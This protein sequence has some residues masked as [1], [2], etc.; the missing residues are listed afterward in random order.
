MPTRILTA[1]LL[2]LTSLTASAHEYNFGTLH[3][4]HPHARAT[5][6]QQPA[7]AAWVSIE[8]QGKTADRLLS[9]SSPIAQSSELHEMSM[10]GDVMKMR[11]TGPMEIRPGEK[12]IMQAGGYH[13]MLM[14]LKQQLKAGDKFPLTL[15]F[16]KAGKQEV[17]VTVDG[18]DA[19]K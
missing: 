19:A 12:L 2:L 17:S 5:V 18:K 6:P 4:L 10:Q 15:V 11:E 1:V 3:I 8:N 13:I 9:V 14:G 16:E 7:G